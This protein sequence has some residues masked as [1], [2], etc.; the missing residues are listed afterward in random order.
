MKQKQ[1]SQQIVYVDAN[2][3]ILGRMA[4]VIAK[5]LLNGETIVILNSEMTV[6]SGK[7]SSRVKETKRK[8]E[9]GHPRKGPYWPRRPDR[10]VR[11]AIRGML[12]RRKPKGKESYR[13]LQV[14]NG[15]PLK[16]RDQ[17]METI[18]EANA[19]N[20]KCSYITVGELTKEIGW[21]PPSGD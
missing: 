18:V 5:R 6:I 19:E 12:P 21:N 3:L 14:F 1:K 9:I 15:V 7:R 4:T 11:R 20:L 10:Y 16:Y 8:L 17:T 13:R 2:N